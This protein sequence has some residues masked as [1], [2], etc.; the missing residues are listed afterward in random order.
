MN[1]ESFRQNLVVHLYNRNNTEPIQCRNNESCCQNSYVHWSSSD[2]IHLNGGCQNLEDTPSVT[3]YQL[4]EPYGIKDGLTEFGTYYCNT[5][6]CGYN[7]T[8]IKTFEMLAREYV[9]PVNL[10]VIDATTL[11]WATIPTTSP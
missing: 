6:N 7:I 10:S 2:N 4:Y 3:C 9:L 1:I 8:A 5:P 11:L